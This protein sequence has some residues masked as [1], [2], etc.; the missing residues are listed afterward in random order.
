VKGRL[1]L[2]LQGMRAALMPRGG[3]ESI[4]G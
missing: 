4:R 1:R 2:G 3:E